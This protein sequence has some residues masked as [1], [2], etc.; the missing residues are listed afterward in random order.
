MLLKGLDEAQPRPRPQHAAEMVL[1]RLCYVADLP[2]P[3]DAIK[4]SRTARGG[5]NASAAR[6]GAWRPPRAAAGRP[7]RRRSP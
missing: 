3:A 4:A 7:A 5:G 6:A 2:S 1:I